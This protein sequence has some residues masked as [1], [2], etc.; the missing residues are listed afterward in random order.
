MMNALKNR[1]ITAALLLPIL[2]AA[3]LEA[4]ADVLRLKLEDQIT[5]AS[6]EVIIT[7]IDQAE[8]RQATAV[9]IMLYTPGGLDTSMREIISRILSSRVPVI[10]YV[11]PSGARAASAGFIIL[12]AADVAAMS[13]GT[14][15]GA[16]HPV[17]MGGGDI[18]ETMKEKVVNDASAY[19][20]SLAEK[21]GRNP[22]A[23]E[24]A[25]RESRSFT[26]REAMENK[27][28]EIIA[29]DEG[30]LLAQ[31]D[32]RTIT[33]FDGSR[34]VLR[35]SG[36]QIAELSPTFRQ[37]LL[38]ALADPRIAFV[39]FAIGALCVYFEFQHPGA[40]VPGVV[41]AVSVV[42]AL[43]GFHMLPI[44]LTGVLLIGVAL[45]LFVLEAKVQ[46]FGILGGGG[47][48]AA[49]IG[50]LILIDVPWESELRLPIG[51]VLA[52]V[53]PFAL[54]TI[55]MIRLALRSRHTKV[56]TGSAGMIGLKGRAHT[57]I[58]PE[59]MVFVRGELWHARSHMK[60]AK[61]ETIRVL[62]MEGLTLEVEAEKD[63]AIMPKKASAIEEQSANSS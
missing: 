53:I 60:I 63:D 29:R 19:V 9:I 55:L 20:R 6:A 62:N 5:P 8:Q 31:L 10:V 43:Y 45:A 15:T 30:D 25:V 61:G 40:V 1:I 34:V 35:T 24:S 2:L 32:G 21:R 7:A 28:I 17:M 46:G 47:I 22:Q 49:I 57:P 26:E 39:L 3:T 58:E 37:R 44:N 13:P 50:S 12:L 59:G 42:L 23:A 33:R 36:E 16:A 4:R 48:V 52:V 27:L 54:I 38:M 11:A 56:T 14:A 41:G 18:E 51:L